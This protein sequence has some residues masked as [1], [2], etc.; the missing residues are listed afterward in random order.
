MQTLA[1]YLFE[2]TTLSHGEVAISAANIEVELNEWLLEKGASNPDVQS[3]NFVSKTRG[4]PAGQFQRRGATSEIGKF[5]ELTLQEQ[6]PSGQRFIT[7]ITLLALVD[8]VVVYATLSVENVATIVAPVFTDPRCPSIVKRLLELRSDWH[9]GNFAIPR[10]VAQQFHGT[11]GG[12]LLTSMIQD[13]AR[14]LPIVVVSEIEQEPIWDDLEV[15]LAADLAGLASVI[16]IDEEASWVL[17]DELGKPN[18]CY[19]GAVRLYW[20]CGKELDASHAPKSSVWT[21]SYMLSQDTDDKGMQRIRA[22][23]RH[24]IMGVASLTVEPPFEIRT[25]QNQAARAKLFE[26]E[27]RANSNSEEIELARLFIQENEE[28]KAS[29]DE[30]KKEIA[31]QASKVDAAEY[32]LSRM[33]ENSG[34]DE[35]EA[36][37]LSESI[38]PIG[39]ETRYY[40][41][42]RNTPSHDVLVRV[43]DCKHNAWQGANSADKAKKGVERLEGIST[44]KNFYHCSKCTGGGVWKVIW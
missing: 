15:R 23:V 29:L 43:K 4:A 44:W 22:L 39:G 26:L 16:R 18:S 13:P 36:E 11:E 6:A 2:S 3:G 12:R 42:T 27:Q 21:A 35:P 37:D 20:P 33:K 17:T 34:L 8:R 25:I 19:L 1:A 9:I 14:I 28:L 24:R 31:R 32:A 40:K 5:G 41:K 38:A 7:A 30:A 10:S